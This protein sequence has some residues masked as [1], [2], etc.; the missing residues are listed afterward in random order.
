MDVSVFHEDDSLS[1]YMTVKTYNTIVMERIWIGK[2]MSQL[3]MQ[4]L[5]RTMSM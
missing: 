3:F 1:R 4:T 2:I 5:A